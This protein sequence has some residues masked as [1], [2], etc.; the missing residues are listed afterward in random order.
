MQFDHV[1]VVV[2][3]TDETMLLFS[4]LFGFE[5]EEVQTFPDQG[6]KSTIAAK[7][8]VRIE[9]IEPIGEEGIIQK[10]ISKKGYGLHHIS[11]RFPDVEKKIGALKEKGAQLINHKPVPITDDSSIAFLQPASTAGVLIELIHRKQA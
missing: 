8:R 5:I 10:F 4:N 1:G 7:D 3:N 9:L 6:F 11:L 2:K